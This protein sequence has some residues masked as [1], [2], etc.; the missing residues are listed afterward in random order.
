MPINESD[1]KR[2]RELREKIGRGFLETTFA[3][4]ERLRDEE[5][6]NEMNEIIK[7]LESILD[8]V[9][10]NLK[11]NDTELKIVNYLS[12]DDLVQVRVHFMNI[13]TKKEKLTDEN[14]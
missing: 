7:K 6:K 13:L 4:S 12:Q 1:L 8:K 5:V 3:V 11:N 9:L 10:E 2:F 14:F